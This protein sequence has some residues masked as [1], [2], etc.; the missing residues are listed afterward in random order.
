[1]ESRAGPSL[2]VPAMPA[3]LAASQRCVFAHPARCLISVLVKGL[4][5]P[6]NGFI[7]KCTGVQ[8]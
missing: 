7:A 2:A 6:G 5:H 4:S 3:A 1:M 8:L